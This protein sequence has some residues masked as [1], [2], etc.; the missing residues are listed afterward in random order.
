[1]SVPQKMSNV[2]NFPLTREE[3]DDIPVIGLYSSFTPTCKGMDDAG[4]YVKERILD[5][6][7]HVLIR[8]GICRAH[9]VDRF[10]DEHAVM[11]WKKDTILNGGTNDVSQEKLDE[12]RLKVHGNIVKPA[13]IIKHSELMRVADSEYR[14]LCPECGTG[15][16][17]MR[18]ND[19]MSLSQWDNCLS[20]G[21]KFQYIDIVTGSN[22]RELI[23]RTQHEMASALIEQ[24][25]ATD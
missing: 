22:I 3:Y 17:M 23:Y 11:C 19:D 15:L 2:I 10:F 18:R 9:T 7:D 12:W 6:K 25:K 24:Q 21:C 4:E 13:Q 8:C 16:L 14:S 20:C 5:P 1:M